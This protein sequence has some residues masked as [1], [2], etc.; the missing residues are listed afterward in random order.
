M[1]VES[2]K[3]KSQ[4][5][6]FGKTIIDDIRHG[7]LK[8]TIPRDLKDFYEFYLD[9]ETRAQLESM[10]RVRK[11]IRI[12]FLLAKSLFLKLTPGRRILL[13]LGVLLAISRMSESNN[14]SHIGLIILILVLALE[15]KDKLL[16][17]DELETGRKVQIALMPERNPV[18]DGWDVWLFTR[19]A[20][21]VGGDLV[22]YIWLDHQRLG[23]TLGDVA[24]KGLGAALLMAKLQATLRAL[25]PRRFV[26][27]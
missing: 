17:R 2:S 13:V 4:S 19:P 11:W 6:K 12:T 10:G 25:A 14:Y 7:D 8:R 26:I 18:I 23:I 24:G 27:S 5:P 20:N 1:N 16:A 15:L 21:E 22:D 9:P 3:T